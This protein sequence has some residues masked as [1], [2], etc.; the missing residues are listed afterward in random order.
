MCIIIRLLLP[1]Y[2]VQQTHIGINNFHIYKAKHIYL[3]WECVY[4]IVFKSKLIS[5]NGRTNPSGKK[6]MMPSMH[7]VSLTDN[8]WH[9]AFS[10]LLWKM[11]VACYRN[12]H[13]DCWVN[14][15]RN[16]LESIFKRVTCKVNNTVN[17]VSRVANNDGDTEKL[18][19]TFKGA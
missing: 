5:P 15:R 17:K 18:V 12:T 7:F 3:I 9:L 19:A 14:D 13:H 6:L 2:N 8:T 4:I 10:T 16:S 1:N 11:S